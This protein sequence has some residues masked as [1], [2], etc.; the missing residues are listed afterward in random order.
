[1]D[2]PHRGQW[3]RAL[4]FSLIC[5]WINGWVHNGETG[6]LRRYRAHYDV[7]V[8][9]WTL[10]TIFKSPHVNQ[11]VAVQLCLVLV[12]SWWRHE[13]FPALL[14]LC[15]GNPPV[16]G[17]FPSQRPVTQSIDGFFDLRLNKRL[18]KQSR[19]WRFETPLHSLSRHCNDN[20]EKM[21]N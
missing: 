3:R 7:I 6:D 21:E 2:S 15:E 18:S 16:T 17:G 14:V 9:L 10:N 20:S 19:R 5:V 1:M 13:T 8:M 4:M 12:F 11:F